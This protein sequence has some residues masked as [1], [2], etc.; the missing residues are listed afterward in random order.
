MVVRVG[1]E[2]LRC[3]ILICPTEG[4][5]GVLL[6]LL[7]TPPEITQFCVKIL[8]QED[9]LWLQIPMD[10]VMIMDIFD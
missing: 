8:I 3:H 2:D 6:A 10:D 1:L 5:P 9:I 7:G 4:G